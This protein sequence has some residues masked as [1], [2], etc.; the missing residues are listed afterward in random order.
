MT[1]SPLPLDLHEDMQVWSYRVSHRTLVFRSF[2]TQ[3]RDTATEVEFVSVLAMKTRSGY[4]GLEIRAAG[5]DPEIEAL[6]DVPGPASPRFLRLH[7]LS[8]GVPSGFVV[9]GDVRVREVP[10]DE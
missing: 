6:V 1:T 8:G 2:W 5:P 4:Q 9:C 7:L 3:G 10:V